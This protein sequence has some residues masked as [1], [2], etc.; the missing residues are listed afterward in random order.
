LLDPWKLLVHRE[1]VGQPQVDAYQEKPRCPLLK[2]DLLNLA[3]PVFRGVSVGIAANRPKVLIGP[4]SDLEALAS[5]PAKCIWGGHE[6]TVQWTPKSGYVFGTPGDSR[7]RTLILAGH[8]VFMNGMLVQLDNDNF[9]FAANAIRWLRDGPEGKRKYALMIHDG[10]VID[11]FDLPLT[12]PAKLPMPPV[13]VLN[14][15]L[16][17]LENERVF[18]RLIEETVGWPMVLRFV[19]VVIT[20]ALLAYG[21]YRLLG[22]RHYQEAVPLVVGMTPGPVAGRTVVQQRQLELMAQD[23]L[24]EPAQALARQ[25]FLDH[26]RVNPPLWDEADHARPPAPAYR[27]SWLQRRRLDRHLAALWSYALRDPS[28]QV[29]LRE[30]RRLSAAL[31]ELNGAIVR[32]EIAFRDGGRRAG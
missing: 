16:R 13:H 9:L 22:A 23:N 10:R 1:E 24:W 15:M 25:W 31:E 30:F 8:G 2:P 17:E 21:F 3:H 28:Q 6:M 19:L 29:N 32:G 11:S 5:L 27:A 12:A 7:R 20:M 18:H 4:E 14:R 26:A